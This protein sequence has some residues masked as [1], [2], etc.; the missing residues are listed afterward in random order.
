MRL[1]VNT[2]RI[3]AAL[4]RDS[5]SRAI[6][7]SDKFEFVTV[8]LTK[9]ELNRHKEAILRK[10]KI[11]E[12]DLEKLMSLI[13][14]RQRRYAVYCAGTRCGQRGYMERRSAFSGTKRCSRVDNKRFG[15][16]SVDQH[17]ITESNIL[18]LPP[19]P[20]ELNKVIGAAGEI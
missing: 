11:S 6:L 18:H 14:S 5:T 15:W 2:N 20:R 7:F 10:A 13:F 19:D 12:A 4:I 3:I 8:G 17:L 16:I 1:V 9:V